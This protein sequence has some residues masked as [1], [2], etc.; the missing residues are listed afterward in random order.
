MRRMTEKAGA[1]PYEA[2]IERGWTDTQLIEH[3][4]ML[5]DEQPAVPALTESEHVANIEAAQQENLRNLAAAEDELYEARAS[6]KA[7]EQTGNADAIHECRKWVDRCEH[8]V[9]LY[10]ELLGGAAPEPRAATPVGAPKFG[11]YVTASMMPALFDGYVYVNDIHRIVG[12]S[13]FLMDKAKFDAHPRFAGRDYAMKADG[14]RPSSSAWDAFVLGQIAQGVKVHGLVFKPLERPGAIVEIEGARYVNTWRPVNIRMLPGGADEVRPFLDHL[15]K[16]YPAD[17]RIL[18]N[19]MKF[20]VQHK[21]TKVRWWPFLQGVPGNGKSY[22]SDTMEYCIGHKFTQRPTPKNIDS[23]FN[24][25]LYGC[26][27]LALEDVKVADDYGSMWETLKPMVTQDRLEIQPKGVDKLTR[28]VC[29]NAIINSN[30]KNGIRKT[31]DDR[32]IATFFSAQQRRSDLAR[33]GLTESYFRQLWEWSHADGWAHVAYYLAHDPID[34]DFSHTQCPVTSSTAEAIR[35]GRTPAEQEIGDAIESG[36][37]GFRGGWINMQA[38]DNL[39]ASRN[40]RHI[41]RQTRLDIL[42]G[43][44][45]IAHPGLPDGRVAECLPDGTRPVLYVRTDH[46][47]RGYTNTGQIREAYQRAQQP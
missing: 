27:F 3:G 17:W 14:S 5:P 10:T 43:L 11:D 34:S 7:T 13:G 36:M 38:L 25:S 37:P 35:V 20:M 16:L 21:G 26:L 4:Y 46:P 6:L 42:D 30:S 2:F 31:A 22:I 19:Y 1:V 33:D 47:T 32:R 44:G 41:G 18:L 24:A 29:F 28:E 12:P 40:L 23:E 9:R 39:L 8:D 45:Y 15:Q